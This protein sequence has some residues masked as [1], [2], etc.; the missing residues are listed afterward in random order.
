LNPHALAGTSPS[1]RFRHSCDLARFASSLVV[2]HIGRHLTTRKDTVSHVTIARLLHGDVI[3][4]YGTTRNDAGRWPTLA[5]S[6]SGAG[7]W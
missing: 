4:P 5:G 7:E 6:D 1:S 2:A 3:R